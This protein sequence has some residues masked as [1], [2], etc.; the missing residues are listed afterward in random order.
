MTF[1][2]K[3]A[4]IG[5]QDNSNKIADTNF[6]EELPLCEQFLVDSE[7]QKRNK[8]HSKKQH[9]IFFEKMV[10]EKLDYLFNKSKGAVKLAFR[11]IV[12]LVESG[13]FRY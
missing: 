10:D 11:Y 6:Q 2:M 13:K 3:T 5:P 12:Q 7:F 4:K 8:E 1:Y 9:Q